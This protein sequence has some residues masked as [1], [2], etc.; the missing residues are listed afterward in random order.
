[1]R[2]L[3]RGTSELALLAP[4]R[5][6]ASAWE[7][8]KLLRPTAEGVLIRNA[9]LWQARDSGDGPVGDVVVGP[10]TSASSVGIMDQEQ[11][12]RWLGTAGAVPEVIGE[13]LGP[14][15]TPE[16]AARVL[17]TAAGRDEDKPPV[18]LPLL[19]AAAAVA[20][21]EAVMARVFS[22]AGVGRGVRARGGGG[23][24]GA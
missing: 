3:P 14:G 24:L 8:G 10:D 12:T 5:T 19:I 18:S 4:A 11:L 22:H 16:E 17:A 7:T 9:S 23:V 6:P 2:T 15:A 13:G 21:A 1:V 20:L